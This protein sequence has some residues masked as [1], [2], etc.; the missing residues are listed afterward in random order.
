MKKTNNEETKVT[1]PTNSVKAVKQTAKPKTVKKEVKPKKSLSKVVK[2]TGSELKKVSW[3]TFPK[4]VK[5]TGVVITVVVV[6]TLILFGFD[7][8]FSWLYT[9]LIELVKG[10]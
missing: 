9:L 4:V 2:E 5:Q 1:T 6:F 7:R 8:L 10:A 3:P